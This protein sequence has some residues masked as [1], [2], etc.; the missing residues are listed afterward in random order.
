MHGLDANRPFLTYL[1]KSVVGAH[2]QS[3]SNWVI[4]SNPNFS[5]CDSHRKN[6]SS[7]TATSTHAGTPRHASPLLRKP[8]LRYLRTYV[9]TGRAVQSR[10]WHTRTTTTIQFSVAHHFEKAFRTRDCFDGF[11]L[12]YSFVIILNISY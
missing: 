3:N 6:E 7:R 10:A 9:F 2:S 12:V 4:I 1:A 11:S 8:S 5:R